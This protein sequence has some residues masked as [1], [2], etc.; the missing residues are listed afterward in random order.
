[1]SANEKS[2][3]KFLFLSSGDTDTLWL[4][5]ERCPVWRNRTT[6]IPESFSGPVSIAWELVKCYNQ[7]ALPCNKTCRQ[8]IIDTL[9]KGLLEC[10]QMIVYCSSPCQYLSGKKLLHCCCSAI[11][12]TV[13]TDLKVWF[14]VIFREIA[15]CTSR[16]GILICW[17]WIG[18][19][20][21]PSK[22]HSTMS[23]LI[24]L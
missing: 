10:F 14:C 4:V 16:L 20:N 15:E 1:M 9:A 23:M 11:C 5:L 18:I 24:D 8:W 17:W 6:S 22:F 3:V 13:P 21:P 2:P 19:Q 12:K 7:H